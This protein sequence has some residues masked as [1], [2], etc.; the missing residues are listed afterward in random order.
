M[1]RLC[2]ESFE[3]RVVAA[4]TG[5]SRRTRCYGTVTTCDGGDALFA[6]EG[7]GLTRRQMPIFEKQS[8]FVS[9]N[10]A[11]SAQAR[12]VCAFGYGAA[13]EISIREAAT[14]NLNSLYKS[15]KLNF[16]HVNCLPPADNAHIEI[17]NCERPNSLLHP[18]GRADGSCSEGVD[19]SWTPNAGMLA[20][21]PPKRCR[22]TEL[23]PDG[24]RFLDLPC[25]HRPF[26][27]QPKLAPPTL[28]RTASARQLAKRR[29]R[30]AYAAI[31]PPRESRKK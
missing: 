17:V 27:R 28:G 23:Q 24:R 13:N 10:R 22:L 14:S 3:R 5:L 1:R 18:A 25:Q 16:N 15:G 30:G 8:I 29:K 26:A 31:R 6:C 21:C 4:P 12:I 19:A 7:V 11:C 20:L 2:S 9:V